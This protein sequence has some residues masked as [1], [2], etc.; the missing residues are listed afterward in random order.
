MAKKDTDF[1]EGLTAKQRGDI[2][3]LKQ[4][5]AV[6]ETL[7]GAAEDAGLLRKQDKEKLRKVKK[8]TERIPEI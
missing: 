8:F 3:R 2:K 1:K 5:V 6:L 4:K 7:A